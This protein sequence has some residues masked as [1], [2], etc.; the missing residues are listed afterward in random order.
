MFHVVKNGLAD[1]R[2]IFFFFLVFGVFFSLAFP[3]ISSIGKSLFRLSV[4]S[5]QSEDFGPN[6]S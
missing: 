4:S 5:Q 6:G 2:S 1:G 3:S